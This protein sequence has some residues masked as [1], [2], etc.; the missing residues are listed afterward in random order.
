MSP[1]PN[2][3]AASDQEVVALARQGREEAYAELLRRYQERVYARI[4]HLVRDPELAEDLTQETF[5]RMFHE[6]DTYRPEL[7]FS[8]WILTI[9]NNAA[10][11]HHRRKQPDTLR[12]ANT[13]DL[14]PEPGKSKPTALQLA[15]PSES[16][17]PE[18]DVPRLTPEVRQ[19][20][21]RLRGHYRRCMMLRYYEDRSYDD[22]AE[23]LG[24]PVGSVKGYMHR[25][26]EELRK[27]L[28]PLVDS[29]PSE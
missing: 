9:A 11:D 27:S 21:T 3:S 8:T 20:I 12:L 19:A 15:N 22:I 16:P 26:R 14:T 18:S 6:L 24:L 2:L 1:A 4:H 29:L 17:T 28:G 13:P 10:I 23:I 7:K 5:I 25:A